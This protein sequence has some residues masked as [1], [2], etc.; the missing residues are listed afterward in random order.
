MSDDNIGSDNV[1]C[2][3]GIRKLVW[4]LGDNAVEV[5]KLEI[6]PASQN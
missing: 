3:E 1:D 2:G 6:P 4:I 5:T